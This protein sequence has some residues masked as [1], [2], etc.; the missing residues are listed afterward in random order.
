VALQSARRLGVAETISWPALDMRS[1]MTYSWENWRRPDSGIY[2]K[3]RSA[4]ARFRVI[5]G[6]DLGGILTRAER[7]PSSDLVA[8]SSGWIHLREVLRRD[9]IAG[10][11]P[12]PQHL[13][14]GYGGAV[15]ALYAPLRPDRL[16]PP[17]DPRMLQVR[18]EE[19]LRDPCA[20]VR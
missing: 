18:L 4:L 7:S 13:R 11:R 5:P 10:I 9:Q 8:R 19:E 16:S 15:G 17:D 6:H 1:P 20:T 12:F 14:P 2:G 3:S